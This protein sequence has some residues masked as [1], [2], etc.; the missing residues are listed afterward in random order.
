MGKR[1]YDG[2]YFGF[3]LLFYGIGRAWIEGLR[4]D[5]LYTCTD[6]EAGT[7]YGFGLQA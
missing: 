3:Y 5:R 7:G 1:R 4:T 2:Q 6:I